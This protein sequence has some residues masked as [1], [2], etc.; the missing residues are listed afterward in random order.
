MYAKF[1]LLTVLTLLSSSGL[2]RVWGG[3]PKEVP[4]LT[5]EKIPV[6]KQVATVADLKPLVGTYFIAAQN[7]R[8]DI[9]GDIVYMQTPQPGV[10]V[11]A[12]TRV[13]LWKFVKAAEDRK[14]VDVPNLRGEKAGDAIQS[15]KNLELQ[16]L[17]ILDEE[18]EG[19]ILDQYP[20]PGSKVFVGTSIFLT[21]KK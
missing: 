18:A 6:A 2:E 7:W 19:E 21:L 17:G 16:A 12:G 10:L 3:D 5:G 13:G 8:N 4:K 11:P 9:R 15:L 20:E 14:M 1:V